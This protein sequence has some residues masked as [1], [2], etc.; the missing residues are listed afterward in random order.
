VLAAAAAMLRAVEPADSTDLTPTS[1]RL[2]LRAR[3][4]RS[5]RLL[6][7]RPALAFAL[8]LVLGALAGATVFRGWRRHQESTVTPPAPG[9]SVGVRHHGTRVAATTG[10]LAPS[11]LA[12]APTTTAPEAVVVAAMPIAAPAAPPAPVPAPSSPTPIKPTVKPAAVA[13]A[14]PRTRA[15]VTAAPIAPPPSHPAT[16]AIAAALPPPAKTMASPDLLL[17]SAMR[18]LRFEHDAKHAS[19]LADTYLSLYPDDDLAE[20][21]MAIGIEAHQQLD[22]GVARALAGRYLARFPNGRFR[23]AALRA[24]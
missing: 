11:V 18:A 8:L 23:A 2:R 21:A 10:P 9:S 13:A 6:G 17:Q 4:R 5:S 16:S 24:R 3:P 20:E 7:L 1:M 12:V 14:T 19:E 15:V 22:D